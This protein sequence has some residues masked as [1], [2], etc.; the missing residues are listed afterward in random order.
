MAH[1][2]VLWKPHISQA[3]VGKQGSQ[4]TRFSCIDSFFFS[5]NNLLIKNPNKMQQSASVVHLY[6][7]MQ[8]E[9]KPK[10]CY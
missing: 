6:A 7:G 5:E 3:H 4:V 8:A 10:T 9:P 2:T 1:Y